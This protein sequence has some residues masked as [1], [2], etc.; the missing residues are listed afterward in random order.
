MRTGFDKVVA[1]AV[2]LVVGVL[3]AADASAE[4]GG[5]ASGGDAEETT[6][7]VAVVSFDEGTQAGALIESVSELLDRAK[8]EVIAGSELRRRLGER[9]AGEVSDEVASKF[10]GIS[11]R[12]GDGVK[13][14]FYKG[15][16]TAVEE[17]TPIFDLGMGHPEVLVR[18]PDFAEQIFQAGIVLVRA[19]KNLEREE[20]ARA[21]V[22]RLAR[23]LPGRK[24]SPSTAPPSIIRFFED[25]R[26]KVAK[27]GTRLELQTI[28]DEDCEAYVNGTSVGDETLAVAAGESYYVTLECGSRV[29]PVWQTTLEAGEHAKLPVSSQD[30]LEFTMENG[31]F[32]NRKRAEDYLR[33]ISFWS[34][35][36]Q[37]LGV[38]QQDAPGESGGE[39]E[40]VLVVRVDGSGDATWSDTR[41]S[42]EI[43]R[44]IT[45]VLPDYGSVDSADSG[46]GAAVAERDSGDN[47]WVDWVMVGGGAALIGTG[48]LLT[49]TTERRA[50][51]VQ[52]SPDTGA[53]PGNCR[54]VEVLRFDDDAEIEKA[55][56]EVAWARVGYW[57]AFAAGA[58]LAGW[59]IF[60]LATRDSHA[61]DETA[62]A[63]FMASPRPD[64]ASVG[65]Q[66]RW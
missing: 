32:Q 20:D 65:V 25:E 9:Q 36:P 27:E 30:P 35:I 52:C 40:G 13:S 10:A 64:G 15:N 49:V 12:I 2:S 31:N 61:D 26:E 45:R 48:A 18:R 44:A 21:V 4:S 63:Q 34:G 23:T 59:G 54:D 1:L 16:E 39:G 17:L 37:T 11:N 6:R 14:F 19:Y 29:A 5:E 38:K 3:A 50:R 47:R 58:G 60:R 46:A 43:R 53:D 41:K 42:E 8:Y 55:E 22:R 28:G 51:Q 56:R 33:L 57:S 7:R 62:D 66:V 24:P